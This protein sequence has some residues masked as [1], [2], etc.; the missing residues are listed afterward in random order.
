MPVS[1]DTDTLSL[2]IHGR[3]R[4]LQRIA[5]GGIG[6]VYLGIDEQL[7]RRVAIKRLKR[8]LDEIQLP[9]DSAWQEAKALATLQHP[10]IVTLFDYGEDAFGAFFIMEF[11]DGETLD[12]RL[13]RGPLD[14]DEFVEIAR[15]ALEGVNAAHQ[16]G[17][18]HRDLK[19]SNFMLRPLPNGGI[20]LKVLDFGLA[21]FQEAPSPQTSR[22]D[23]QV[24]GSIYYIAPEQFEQQPVDTR[25]DLYSLGH[26]FYHCLAGQPAY[27][28]QTVYEILNLHMQGTPV[29]LEEI[30]PDIDPA[31]TGWIHRLI[32]RHPAHR[33]RNSAEALEALYNWVRS[34]TSGIIEPAPAIP[35]PPPTPPAPQRQQTPLFLGLA[36]VGLI[37]AIAVAGFL[38]A[39]QGKKKADSAQPV[40]TVPA[41]SGPAPLSPPPPT[42]A[43]PAT[44]SPIPSLAASAPVHDPR[45]LATLRSK[46]G[47]TITLRGTPVALGENRAGTITYLNFTQD[48]RDSVALV[49]FHDDDPEGF[50]KENLQA[51][52]QRPL[53]V[54][55]ELSEHRGNLQLKIRSVRDLRPLSSE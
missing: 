50:R 5:S 45:D 17:I 20:N 23:G 6:N 55:G 43:P 36:A 16:C 18:L 13:Q 28:G 4:Q 35:S 48:Y 25:S 27:R 30:R 54:T 15:Q 11:I 32:Q 42:P 14:Q 21:K 8:D 7:Q 3:Y 49:C 52:L 40:A 24:L 53:E 44:P 26:V 9:P 37:S 1:R 19:P 41:P 10:N 29:R 46:I 2:L 47:Q 31:L 51:F 38:L 33:Y 22:Q 34:Q 12:Q 39:G